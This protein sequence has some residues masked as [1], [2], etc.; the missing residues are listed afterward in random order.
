MDETRIPE[1]VEKIVLLSA[2]PKLLFRRKKKSK[3]ANEARFRKSVQK[4][5]TAVADA[6][7]DGAVAAVG[8]IPKPQSDGMF[9]PFT[10]TVKRLR[11]RGM[12][13]LKMK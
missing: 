6:Q 13:L 5:V 7:R 10:K 9:G 12:K 1:G 11:K 2:E 4:A 3:T 8:R